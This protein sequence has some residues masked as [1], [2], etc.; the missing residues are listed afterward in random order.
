MRALLAVAEFVRSKGMDVMI[1]AGCDDSVFFRR[2]AGRANTENW[3]RIKVKHRQDTS[4]S[5]TRPYPH[6]TVYLDSVKDVRDQKDSLPSMYFVVN[7]DV[8]ACFVVP[9]DPDIWVSKRVWDRANKQTKTMV[10]V[11]IEFCKLASLR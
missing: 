7:A 6:D 1:S 3:S 9:Y 5:E 4:F 11:P 8:S 2:P 10:G